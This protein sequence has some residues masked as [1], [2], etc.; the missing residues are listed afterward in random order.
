MSDDKDRMFPVLGPRPLGAPT[1]VPWAMLAPY[2]ANALDV[3]EQTLERLASRGGLGVSELVQVMDGGGYHAC[4]RPETETLPRLLE[5]LAAFERTRATVGKPIPTL[6]TCPKCATPHVDEG[7]WATR[8]H[9]THLC[10][11]CGNEWRPFEYPTVG[12]ASA[13]RCTSPDCG[14]A[15]H[16]PAPTTT[17]GNA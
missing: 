17:E 15:C 6:L 2:E 8:P 12:V 11:K 3:H 13:C 7:E 14:C 10:V 1:Q 5:L 4:C 9:K 16:K